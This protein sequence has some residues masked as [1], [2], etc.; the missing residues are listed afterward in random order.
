MPK[1]TNPFVTAILPHAIL[2]SEPNGIVNVTCLLEQPF[3]SA[4]IEIL[5][6]DELGF[7]LEWLVP[8][9]RTLKVVVK[10]VVPIIKIS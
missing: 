6:E 1:I 4:E 5:D 8:P 10:F 7:G 2:P 9:N 3:F